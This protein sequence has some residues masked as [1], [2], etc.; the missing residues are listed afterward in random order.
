MGRALILA[1]TLCLAPAAL[2]SPEADARLASGAGHFRAG[3][4]DQAL[5]EFK[6]ARELGARGEVA[7][8]VAAALTKLERSEEALEAFA[9]AAVESPQSADA[10]LGYYHAIACYDAHLLVCADQLLAKVG[11]DAGPRIAGQAAKVRGQIAPILAKEPPRTAIDALLEK[12]ARASAAGRASLAQAYLAEAAA[13]A[14]RRADRYGAE[15]AAQESS[16]RSRD[17]G[18]PERRP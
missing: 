2:A 5:I 3:R 10:L 8:Y 14:A 15:R 12:G 1:L 6:V 18:A 13:L 16:A 9:L 11:G 17:G 4:F 7:W